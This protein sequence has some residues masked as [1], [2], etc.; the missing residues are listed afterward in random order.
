MKHIHLNGL[1]LYLL[2]HLSS[3]S[4]FFLLK[5]VVGGEGRVRACS[6][7]CEGA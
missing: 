1:E 7:A 5:D 4:F 6:Q 2:N 3:S